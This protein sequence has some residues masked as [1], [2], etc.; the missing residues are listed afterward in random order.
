MHNSIVVLNPQE[1]K[2]ISGGIEPFSLIL[3][4]GMAMAVYIGMI[5]LTRV[6]PHND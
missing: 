6:R 4:S 1:I 3:G 5:L 2:D